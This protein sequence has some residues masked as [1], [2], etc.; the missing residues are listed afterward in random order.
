MRLLRTPERMALTSTCR[1]LWARPDILTSTTCWG[2]LRVKLPAAQR[3]RGGAR[4]EE[5]RHVP[6]LCAWLARRRPALRRLLLQGPGVDVAAVLD[7]LAGSA[8]QELQVQGCVLPAEPPLPPSL[9]R[10]ELRGVLGMARLPAALGQLQVLAVTNADLAGLGLG[11][12]A[13]G[14]AHLAQLG[15]S[16]S[17]LDLH[18]CRLE[19]LPASMGSLRALRELDLSQSSFGWGMFSPSG[20]RAFAPLVQLGACLTRLSLARCG[21]ERLPAELSA[22]RTLREL[23]AGHNSLWQSGGSAFA[24][25]TGLT[26]LSRLD[27]RACNLEAVPPTLAGL[28]HLRDL[29]LRDNS[30]G[31][32]HGDS[33]T[34]LAALRA[35]TRLCLAHTNLQHLPVGALSEAL[36]ELR[37][38]QVGEPGRI[39]QA[40]RACAAGRARLQA[41]AALH[42]RPGRWSVWLRG[43]TRFAFPEQ[44]L[45]LS[46]NVAL[47]SRGRLCDVLARLPSLTHVDVRWCKLQPVTLRALHS[48][49]ASLAVTASL[50]LS[51]TNVT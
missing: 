25:V 4:A 2:S 51:H 35:L 24:A 36:S 3:Q 6:S 20:S 12:A 15:A 17:R 8:L 19:L 48:L 47:D 33:F 46:W 30:I 49:R 34:Q 28:V 32:A 11:A 14:S 38:L 31:Y 50:P 39:L 45:Y 23:D 42:P 43:R 9:T 7:G 16:L 44:V 29:V 37:H 41:C 26:A 22:L 18:G 13:H 21:L 1:T 27:A 10:L 40:A 5:A